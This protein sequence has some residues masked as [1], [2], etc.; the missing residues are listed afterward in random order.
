VGLLLGILLVLI[1][2]G[3]LIVL[4]PK[5]YLVLGPAALGAVVSVIWYAWLGMLLLRRGS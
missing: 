1:Y 5:S 3:R 2:L 4:D